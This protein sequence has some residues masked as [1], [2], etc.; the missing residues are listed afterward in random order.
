[1]DSAQPILTGTAAMAPA[2]GAQ[3]PIAPATTGLFGSGGEFSGGR[4]LSATSALTTGLGAY[5]SYAS[6]TQASS[7]FKLQAGSQELQADVVR[8]NAIEKG[9][10]LRRQLLQDLG[11]ANASAA[12]RGID[13]GSGSPR[14]VQIQSIAETQRDVAKIESGADIDV[15]NYQTAASRS[16]GQAASAEYG[17]YVNAIKGL[18]SYL[19]GKI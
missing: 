9:N 5:G 17:G 12:A 19:T 15:S 18:G 8:L 16:R 1:M 6:G 10:I 3:G 7:Q 4:L 13:V 2:A 14:Q 11:S